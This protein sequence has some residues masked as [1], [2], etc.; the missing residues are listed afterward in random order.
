MKTL[1]LMF[2]CLFFVFADG[3][4]LPENWENATPLAKEEQDQSLDSQYNPEVKSDFKALMSALEFRIR[5][6]YKPR[7]LHVP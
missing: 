4:T 6:L 5:E 1:V 3:Q 7:G 2:L